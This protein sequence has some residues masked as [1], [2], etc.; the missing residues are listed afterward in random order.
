VVKAKYR[1]MRAV[2]QPFYKKIWK[3][4][5]KAL[6]SMPSFEEAKKELQV[7]SLHFSNKLIHTPHALLY[8][9]FPRTC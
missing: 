2:Q 1:M 6:I 5:T 8:S 7:F 3:T 4:R 9:L